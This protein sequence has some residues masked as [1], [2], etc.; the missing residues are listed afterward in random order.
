M[1]MGTAVIFDVRMDHDEQREAAEAAVTEANSWLH[2]VDE[3]FTTYADTS[4]VMR[5]RRDEISVDQCPIEVAEVIEACHEWRERTDGWF[6]AWAGPDGF[7][8]SGYVKGWAAQRASDLLRARGFERHCVNAGG[9]VVAAGTPGD[10][11]TWGIGVVD[12]FDR[13]RV[14]CAL[15]VADA[16]VATSG[17]GE[18]GLHVWRRDG[19]PAQTLASVTVIA[20]DLIRAD[21]LATAALAMGE[22]AQ[23]WLAGLG[24]D[25][26]LIDA[27]GAETLTGGVAALLQRLP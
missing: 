4:F 10:V 26:L 22:L 15:R 12:P 7:D 11:A 6:D 16:A 9:D 13:Q 19:S 2:W 14:W 3:T 24:V 17:I 5:L 8:P 1:V 23:P 27:S 18:R 21:V 25:A 20:G